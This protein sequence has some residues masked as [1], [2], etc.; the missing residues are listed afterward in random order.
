MDRLRFDNISFGYGDRT[1]FEGLSLDI[2]KARITSIIGPNGCG[3]SS[4]LKLASAIH[5]P[6]EGGIS[7]FGRKVGE[8]RP[9]QRAQLIGH[10]S[11]EHSMPPMSVR[12]LVECGRH[13]LCAD[14]CLRQGNRGRGP[15]HLRAFGIG[16]T[17]RAR[18]FR[19]TAAARLHCHDRCPRRPSNAP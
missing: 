18:T 9:K 10:L 13:P 3:K 2:K 19:R 12:K 11:Q 6:R 16:R 17:T 4:L 14:G 1:L 5:K 8:L 15:I 7:V